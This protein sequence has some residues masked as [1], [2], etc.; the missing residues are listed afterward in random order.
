MSK[1]QLAELETEMATLTASELADERMV[2]LYEIRF[3]RNKA[4]R[5]EQQKDREIQER[6]EA[7][8]KLSRFSGLS[9]AQLEEMRSSLKLKSIE[10]L[11]GEASKIIGVLPWLNYVKQEEA[12]TDLS[13]KEKFWSDLLAYY[14]REWRDGDE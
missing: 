8:A 10:Q 9:D 12:I 14:Q 6:K 1:D 3:W 5:A 2:M 13:L 4:W 11:K 7:E